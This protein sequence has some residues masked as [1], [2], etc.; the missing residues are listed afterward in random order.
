MSNLK[1]LPVTVSTERIKEMY[2]KISRVYTII[3]EF[4]E[5]KARKRGLA[6]LNPKIGEQI[7]EIG[8]GTACALVEIAK[9]VGNE[10]R[11]YGIDIT[12][13]MIHLAKRRLRL[14]SLSERV[15]LFRGDARSLPYCA[16]QFDAAYIALTL[17]LFDTQDIP[18][19]LDEIKRTLKKEGR[20]V[21][22]SMGKK[23]YEDSVFVK[24]YEFFHRTFPQ[25]LDCRPIYLVDMLKA[26]GYTVKKTEEFKLLGVCPVKA[27]LS[28]L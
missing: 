24:L 25:Y 9:S 2:G 8:V 26:A 21:V 20:L 6:L 11:A 4:F 15:E 16:E 17:E 1:M 23:G 12:E 14:N 3:E 18:R 7:L 10:G 5:R 27:T 13:E 19:V 22:V 28:R